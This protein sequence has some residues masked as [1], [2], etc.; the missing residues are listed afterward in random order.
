MA[1]DVAA[2]GFKGMNNLPGTLA[3]L[4]DDERQ[5]TPRIVLNADVT[6]GGQILARNGFTPVK[7][8]SGTHSLWGG[9]LL[10]C[11]A[12]GASGVPAL[13]RLEG[14]TAIEI[15]TAEGPWQL[16][17][18]QEANGLI[19]ISKPS[20]SAILDPLSG[21]VRSWGVPL[22]PAPDMSVTAGDMPPGA[23]FLTYTNVQDG[24]I[25][26]NGPVTRIGWSGED[27]GIRLNNL[28]AGALCWITHAEGGDMFLALHTGNIIS[29]PSPEAQELPTFMC[30][31][32]PGFAHFACEHG[33]IWGV[34]G[35]KLY[36]SESN[37]YELFRDGATIPFNDDL[38]MVA[39]TTNG[40]FVNSLANTWFLDGTDPALMKKERVGDGALMGSLTYAQMSG[41][42][43]GGGYEISR[44]LTQMPSPIWTT[45]RG[46]VVGTQTGH[47]VHL[48]D[49]KI[50]INSRTFGAGLYRVQDGVPQV[51]MSLYGESLNPDPDLTVIFEENQLFRE[52]G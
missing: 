46:I 40:V 32:C 19:Y 38:V 5:I 43:V 20:W 2:Y 21:A 12:N 34:R 25:G 1:K 31:P 41:P 37:R 27:A 8:L 16:T 30:G 50:K 35:K 14:E 26:G 36:F 49:G 17:T 51:I 6:D 42:S 24:R 22:P 4:L 9:S 3:R 28:P 48:T 44:K 33:R 11:I 29:R 13:F 45:K 52:G 39:P 10:L 15:C 23:Y 47:V 7:A 18:F